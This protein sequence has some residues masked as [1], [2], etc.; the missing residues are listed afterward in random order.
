[1]LSLVETV[2]VV[3][4]ES[5]RGVL[6]FWRN[7]SGTNFVGPHA[8]AAR[9]LEDP[10][11]DCHEDSWNHLKDVVREAEHDRAYETDAS[12]P[13]EP[14]YPESDAVHVRRHGVGLGHT[15][16]KRM[17]V[18]VH[19]R[20]EP[21]EERKQHWVHQQSKDYCPVFRAAF[22][23]FPEGYHG[24]FLVPLIG[25][26]AFCRSSSS[27]FFAAI[28]ISRIQLMSMIP[29]LAFGGSARRNSRS[30]V[31]IFMQTKSEGS[32]ASSICWS[33]MP[34]PSLQLQP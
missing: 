11:K 10:N 2:I 30:L 25:L 28:K 29:V 16:R 13:R 22:E 23:Q 34:C 3:Q 6:V 32:S 17:F 7:D 20:I 18:D 12:R 26:V 33:L 15:A 8:E 14:S 19:G 27:A 31:T 9:D 24:T 1:M 21:T 4:V 5:T